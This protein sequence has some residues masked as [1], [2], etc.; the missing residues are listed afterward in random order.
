MPIERVMLGWD[1]P[2]LEAAVE[3]VGARF[4]DGMVLDLSGLVVA[5]PGAR[6][7]RRLLELLVERA[8]ETRLVL[9]PP[10]IVTVGRLPEKLY[11]AQ[12]PFAPE[13]V[14][15]LA[16]VESLRRA[17][18]ERLGRLVSRPPEAD[19]LAGWLALGEMLGR[20][21]RELAA[22]AMDFQTV[23]DCGQRMA[24]FREEARWNVL[25]HLQEAY[26]AILD[27][28]E[29]WDRQ[30]ARLF[31]LRGGEC[32]TD[33]T[34][35]LL[36]TV[37]MNRA[38][39]EM[40]EQVGDRV[41]ALVFAPEELATRFDALGCLDP[42]RWQKASI[43][44]SAERITVAEG[45]AEQAAA[46]VETI[47]GFDGRFAAEEITVGVPDA[48][49]V[50]H[51]EQ[52]LQ[53]AGLAARHGAGV[54]VSRTAPCRLLSAVA[55]YLDGRTFE[56]F[57]ALVRHPA[58][59]DW[60]ES[61]PIEG[62]WLSAMDTYH[63]L[64]LPHRAGP[65]WLGRPE[66]SE[67]VGQVFEAIEELLGTIN[68]G[69]QVAERSEAPESSPSGAPLR[70]APATQESVALGPTISKKRS[71]G[72]W[73]EAV[74]ELIV[75][76]FGR[77]PL[78]PDD[79][80]DR[81][82]LSTCEKIHEVLAE[83]REIPEALS[84]KLGPAEALR[85][86]LRRASSQRISPPSG[87]E[88]IELL[89]WLEL[90]L[91]DAPALIVT[92][93]NEG[94]VPTAVNEDPFLPNQLRHELGI[95][96]NDRR[97]ARDAY[98]L[99]ALAAS[100]RDLRLIV[101]RRSTEGDPM[102]PSRLLFANDAETAARRAVQL[103][104]SLHTP[105]STSLGPGMLHPGPG[106]WRRDPPRPEPLAEPVTSM[107]VTEFRDYLACPYRYYLRH[108]LQLEPLADRSDELDGRAFGSLSHEVLQHFGQ[109]DAAGLSD[110][111]AIAA[112]LEKRL[113]Q[114][115]AAFWG[116]HPWPAVLV[117]VEQL[118]A[119]LRRFAQW[120][121]DHTARGWRIL[122][123]EWS[124]QDDAALLEVDGRPMRLHGRIDRIDV[125]DAS[126]RML[127]TDYKT[128]DSPKKPEAAHRTRDGWIDLQLPLY[129]H[130]VQPIAPDEGIELG[131]LVLPKDLSKV[132][133][134][135][136]DWSE[137]DLREADEMARSVVRAVRNET[138][139][140]P[141]QPPPAFS[142]DFAAIC[143]DGRFGA[144]M[145]DDAEDGNGEGGDE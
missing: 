4:G 55:D 119:R 88:A 127:L 38:Q 69:W 92:G 144:A 118:R 22:E 5:V 85:L 54:P 107:R 128:S 86:V 18:P 115:V 46:V 35:V 66:E 122:H 65:P 34:I 11:Q 27:S 116:K 102:L 33:R 141:V 121:A 105:A 51:L 142:E 89:G 132:G 71:L 143:Q 37:D 98:A 100:G 13:L 16:W 44:L 80:D 114:L 110:P 20:L 24:G 93:M 130:L 87:Q 21:H 64:H 19:D 131:Y 2:A 58:M 140:P 61:R 14:Q 45:P 60:L 9:T 29:L 90:P 56:S 52:R 111:D 39:R 73:A 30:T 123:T 109:S 50:P 72:D 40:L 1:R 53:L 96:D 139:W 49:V 124:P 67:M 17:E 47:A 57:A 106:H 43:D 95:E 117:Q 36:G 126:G 125:H 112:V 82:V 129:R 103:F 75:T 10:E 133:L 42:G 25:R 31:A 59:H 99:S 68:P 91:D 41:I 138:F 79:P 26:L 120:Q 104:G 32:R 108:C 7:G 74:I 136:A 6:A 48:R 28:L 77:E 97:F 135:K 83:G 76:L 23:V 8:E 78:D 94:I 3:W 101:G 137:D 113:E 70:S 81:A 62:D 134:L 84:P 145:I 15:Q 12:R 63:E